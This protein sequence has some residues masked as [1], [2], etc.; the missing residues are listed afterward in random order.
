VA[1]ARDS[2]VTV[3]A[4]THF[5]MATEPRSSRMVV[6]EARGIETF[7][8]PINPPGA[9]PS[10][11]DAWRIFQYPYLVSVALIDRRFQTP[12]AVALIRLCWAY[13]AT[14]AFVALGFAGGCLLARRSSN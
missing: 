10:L 13:W 12:V 8:I 4:P 9:D 5:I 2:V 6:D 14:L 11:M 1:P 7:E 3:S